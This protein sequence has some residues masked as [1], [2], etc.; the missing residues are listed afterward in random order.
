MKLQ[1]RFSRKHLLA[2][3][4]AL[5]AVG[6]VM[7][8]QVA[9]P[10]REATGSLLSPLS[11]APMWA[12]T[13]LGSRVSAP[14][15]NRISAK[16]AA[17][18]RRQIDELNRLVAFLGF[19]AELHRKRGEDLANFQR[20]YGPTHDLACELIPARVV[21]GGS[22]PY[23]GTRMLTRGSRRTVHPG[24]AV[25]TRQLVTDRSKLLPPLLSVVNSNF[26]VGRITV[27]GAFT[28]R[29]QLLTDRDFE[30]YGRVRR[31]ISSRPR[32]MVTVKE[33]ELPRTAPLTPES[34]YPIDVI[35]HGDGAGHLIV[36]DV[37]EQHKVQQGDLLVTSAD[38]GDVPTEIHI[39]EVVEVSSDPKDARRVTLTVKPHADL[40]N[41]RDVYI[42]SPVEP[43]SGSP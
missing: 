5:S 34:N 33:G 23:D 40:E 1:A 19:R 39:G 15:Q 11:D 9:D 27:S 26:L 43:P 3:L 31:V 36:P 42:L 35:A 21:A 24:S 28:A 37:E 8:P 6:S 12:V 30:I 38:H 14:R 22:L 25:T 29:L 10:L 7:G 17:E 2:V 18:L 41:I 32:E 4:L 20:M 16:E 13:E